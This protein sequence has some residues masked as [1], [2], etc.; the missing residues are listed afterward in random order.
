MGMRDTGAMV[1]W[2]SGTIRSPRCMRGYVK[3]TPFRILKLSVSPLLVVATP[4]ANR[5][6]PVGGDG[7]SIGGMLIWCMGKAVHRY[8]GVMQEGN[9]YAGNRRSEPE[10]WLSRALG[11]RVWPNLASVLG[12]DEPA[13]LLL[14]CGAAAVGWGSEVNPQPGFASD[15]TGGKRERWSAR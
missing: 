10:G 14:D 15:G 4:M 13:A 2:C 3:G 11:K 1:Q 7:A 9:S 8:V 12:S 5:L 6:K